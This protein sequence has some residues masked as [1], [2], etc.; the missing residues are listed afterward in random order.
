LDLSA[1]HDS[2][3]EVNQSAVAGTAATRRADVGM[4][5]ILPLPQQLLRRRHRWSMVS[6]DLTA[7]GRRTRGCRSTTGKCA[8]PRHPLASAVSAQVAGL[9]R[10]S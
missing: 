4:G 7:R 9:V 5:G 6:L 8:L 2:R 1:R 10:R 3:G